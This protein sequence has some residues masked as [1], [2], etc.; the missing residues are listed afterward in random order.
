MKLSRGDL[1]KDSKITYTL[2]DSRIVFD[3]TNQLT[4]FTE[5]H[6]LT[7]KLEAFFRL[8]EY[9]AKRKAEWNLIQRFKSDNSG[10]FDSAACKE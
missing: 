8:K 10:E 6:L 9:T 4:D 1:A 2:W 7:K 3:L 5:I